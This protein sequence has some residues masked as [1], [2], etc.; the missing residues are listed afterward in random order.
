[1]TFTKNE[2]SFCNIGFL[3]LFSDFSTWLFTGFLYYLFKFHGWRNTIEFSLF[4]FNHKMHFHKF[5]M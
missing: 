4:I 1:M 2:I 3:S 5:F